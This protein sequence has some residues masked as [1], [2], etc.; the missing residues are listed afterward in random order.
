MQDCGSPSAV[1]IRKG[2]SEEVT[3][4]MGLEGCVC[5]PGRLGGRARLQGEETT[6]P[7]PDC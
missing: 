2:F 5:V 4:E 3:L 1:V 7:G 6:P